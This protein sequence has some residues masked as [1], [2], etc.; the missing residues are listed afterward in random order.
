MERERDSVVGT[1]ETRDFSKALLVQA[2]VPGFLRQIHGGKKL[3]SEKSRGA[4]LKHGNVSETGREEQIF[5]ISLGN[6][7]FLTRGV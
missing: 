6:L 4:Y 2:A 1:L 7:F 3:R 5:S